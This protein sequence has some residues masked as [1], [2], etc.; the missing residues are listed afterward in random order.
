MER[1]LKHYPSGKWRPEAE[2]LD[3]G[4]AISG[5]KSSAEAADLFNR[6]WKR[7]PK[8]PLA[9]SARYALGLESGFSREVL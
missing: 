9:E 7:Y 3:G 6:F 1:L 4:I 2:Y 5:S 8:H